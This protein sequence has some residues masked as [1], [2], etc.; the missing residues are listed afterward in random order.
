MVLLLMEK[1][2]PVANIVIGLNEEL[3]DKAL[4]DGIAIDSDIK[5][6]DHGALAFISKKEI[7]PY[8]FSFYRK[9]LKIVP[10]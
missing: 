2:N 7:I 10:V 6:F 3:K 4:E 1:K 8:I 9:H 5:P